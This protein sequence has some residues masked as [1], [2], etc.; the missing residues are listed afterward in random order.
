MGQLKRAR[1]TYWLLVVINFIAVMYNASL[2][3]LISNYVAR[4]NLSLQLLTKLNVVPGNINLMYWLAVLLYAFLIC[5]ICIRRNGGEKA[6]LWLL[7]EL[8]TIMGLFW[9]IKASY[10]G[11]IFLIFADIFFSTDNF[12]TIKNKYYW[13]I[14]IIVAGMI[15]LLSND[16]LLASIITLPSLDTYI[17]MLPLR[18]GILVTFIRNFLTTI[19]IVIFAAALFTYV[20]YITN[21]QRNIEEELRMMDRAN[22]ELKSYIEVAER[23][24]ER[25][26]RI[27][28]SREIHDTLG[29]ALTGISAGIDAVL[30]LVDMDKESAKAQLRNLSEVVR[31]GIID[32]R[33]SLNKM[34]PGALEEL[35]LEDSLQEMIKRYSQ[36][37]ELQI[38]LTYDWQGIDLPKTTENVIFRIIEESITNSI[39]HGQA[40]K[41][42]ITLSQDE[43]YNYLE[44]VDNGRGSQEIKPGFGLTQMQERLAIIGGKVTYQGDHGFKIKV[45]FVK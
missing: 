27:R 17:G 3:L 4:K 21:E 24:A 31:Q 26:E 35:S 40:E 39:R 1:Y 8:V 10:T 44:I 11:L 33:N 22:A 41:I 6:E 9:T 29:H 2:Y 36:I 28:I 12:Y 23:N 32:V 34:R 38:K 18:L 7:L 45:K 43:K 25:R 30:V 42:W 20:V 15:L 13:G 5:L 19:N 37:S 16:R 14:F